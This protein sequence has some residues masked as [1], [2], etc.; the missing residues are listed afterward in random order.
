MEC[1]LQ[2]R[3]TG[4]TQQLPT[5]TWRGCPD[6]ASSQ[7]SSQMPA[8]NIPGHMGYPPKC[9]GCC[10]GTAAVRTKEINA[11]MSFAPGH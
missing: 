1:H 7:R 11:L 4:H 2:R 6:P 8:A 3:V 5:E 9:S 10:D